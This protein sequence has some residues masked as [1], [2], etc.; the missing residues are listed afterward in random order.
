MRRAVTFRTSRFESRVPKPHFIN[1]NCFGEDLA[2]WLRPGLQAAGIE[3]GE[4]IQED[5]GWGV[6]ADMGGD[7]YWLAMSSIDEDAG[8]EDGVG[9]ET[10]SATQAA[11]WAIIIAYEPGFSLWKRFTHRARPEELARLC[12]AIDAKLR[13]E[14]EILEIAWWDDDPFR[15]TSR[16][17]P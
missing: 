16:E 12:S 17:H 6:W 9:V 13:T 4:P 1:P 8:G 5:Y 2:A 10:K 3:P 14:P 11:E 7:P 15:G